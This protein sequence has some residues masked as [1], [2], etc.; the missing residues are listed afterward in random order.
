M[1]SNRRLRKRLNTSIVLALVA[2]VLLPRCG[3]EHVDAPALPPDPQQ[4]PA[5]CR[6]L[7]AQMPRFFEMMRDPARPL[8]SLRDAVQRLSR[9]EPGEYT[10]MS[11]LLSS[12][13]NGL[14]DFTDDPW[15][16]S[17][18]GCESRPPGLP[19]CFVDVPRS[20]ECESRACALRRTLDF[21]LRDEG[22]NQAIDD[23][24]PLLA[25]L[26]GYMSNTGQGADGKEHYEIVEVLHRSSQ[27]EALCSPANLLDVLDGIVLYL[28]GDP[29][30]G[31]GCPG[32]R[33]IDVLKRLLNDP[34]L[35][36]F[37]SSFQSS[38]ADGQG[39]A[40]F[41]TIARVL[42]QNLSQIDEAS[43]YQQLEEIVSLYLRPF[44]DSDSSGKWNDLSDT[45]DELLVLL[46]D[47][48]D[49]QRP[50]S[51]VKP[52]KGVI[53]CLSVIDKDQQIVG[54][55]YDL[56][57]KPTESGQGVD[58]GELVDVIDRAIRLDRDGTIATALHAIFASSRKSEIAMSAWRG[59]FGEILT[60]ENARDMVPVLREML[61]RDVLDE[62]F[63][64]V[65]S[66][67]YGC[68]AP[69]VN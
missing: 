21:G 25:K 33:M 31:D 54:A 10:P 13:V 16:R 17:N 15:E 27:Y 7:E 6:T 22:M 19:M 66:L 20:V 29:S 64:V 14:R 61:E 35:E 36:E 60:V 4:T 52:L 58:L 34:T 8:A 26:L 1:S 42:M 45:I 3:A 57:S 49:P 11:T 65:N 41:Q 55:L 28:R 44:F 50:G 2:L 32:R 62:L 46:K 43:Y 12:G 24:K 53:R 48:L 63:V 67:L 56:L 38:Q 40:A 69:V 23:M 37:L 68:R 51:F 47:L 18:K 59:F 9:G 39:R 30:C 5:P